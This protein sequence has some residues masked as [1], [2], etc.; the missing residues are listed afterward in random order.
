M[1]LKTWKDEFYPVE[2]DKVEGRLEAIQHS[3]VKWV[4]VRGDNLKKHKVKL[5]GTSLAGTRGSIG[6]DSYSCALCSLYLRTSKVRCSECPLVA[7]RG[8][9]SCDTKLDLGE[10]LSPYHY[11]AL[12]GNPE[13]MIELLEKALE[14]EKC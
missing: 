1:S 7:I 10:G 14:L 13:P 3:L 6:I 8:G 9:C 11:F 12:E 5:I 2:A 4:G